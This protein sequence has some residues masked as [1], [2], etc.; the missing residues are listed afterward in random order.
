MSA[1][2]SEARR[3]ASKTPGRRAHH[4]ALTATILA[5]MLANPEVANRQ[6]VVAT[7]QGTQYPDLLVDI[8]FDF[9]QKIILLGSERYYGRPQ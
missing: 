6:A 5:G 1:P 8:A 7:R 4:E 9:A 2:R 3:G